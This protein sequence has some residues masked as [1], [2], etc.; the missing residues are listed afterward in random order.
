MKWPVGWRI[1]MTDIKLSVETTADIDPEGIQTV[2]FIGDTDIP[3]VE[4]IEPWEDIIDLNIQYYTVRG[5]FA[6]LHRNDINMLIY[7]LQNALELL[8]KKVDEIGYE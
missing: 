6:E 3:Q 1:W 4:V 5:K 2:V 8:N 7:S